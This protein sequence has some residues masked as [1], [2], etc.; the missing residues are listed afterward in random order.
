MRSQIVTSK[1]EVSTKSLLSEK[2]AEV[3]KNEATR[4]PVAHNRSKEAALA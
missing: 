4:Q 1:M 3:A 2:K